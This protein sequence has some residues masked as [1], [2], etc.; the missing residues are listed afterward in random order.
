MHGYIV[1]KDGSSDDPTAICQYTACSIP[2]FV[3]EDH[4][5]AMY[6][7]F[8]QNAGNAQVWLNYKFDPSEALGNHQRADLLFKKWSQSSLSMSL[9][10]RLKSLS[11]PSVS[12]TVDYDKL[13]KV[14]SESIAGGV[15]VS[16]DVND[17][18][19]YAIEKARQ[20][21]ADKILELQEEIKALTES[22]TETELEI[23]SILDWI[24][25]LSRVNGELLSPCAQGLSK[26]SRAPANDHARRL[27][28]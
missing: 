2:Q 5:D 15:K 8:M 10:T 12:S 13:S 28:S 3:S 22:H 23:S 6:F 16:V 27:R 4:V 25:E 26:C 21:D 20:S 14:L 1:K 19:K 24:V 11:Q 18:T 17:A 7:A 9:M